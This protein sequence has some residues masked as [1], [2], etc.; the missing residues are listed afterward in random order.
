MVAKYVVSP[1][2]G[3]GVHADITS[4][5]LAAARRGRAALIEIAPA[6]RG[7][8]HRTGRGPARRGG[9]ARL[10]GGGPGARNRPRRVREQSVSTASS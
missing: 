10:G 1:R 6:V 4:A 5:L 9:G 2:G 7:S 3:R 8:P